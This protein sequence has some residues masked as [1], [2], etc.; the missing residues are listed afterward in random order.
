M[1]VA[2][3]RT[4]LPAGRAAAGPPAG[5]SQG[6]GTPYAA[7]AVGVDDEVDEVARALEDTW[8]P[9]P[10]TRTAA[11]D[12]LCPCRLKADYPA[13]WNRLLGMATDENARVRSHVLHVLADGSPRAREAEVVQAVEGM[14]QDPDPGLRRRVRKLLAQYRRTGKINIL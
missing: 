10:R 8:S 6:A 11:V 4:T 14:Q 13:V 3:M 7:P 12:Q 5:R 9:D 1:S 2:T